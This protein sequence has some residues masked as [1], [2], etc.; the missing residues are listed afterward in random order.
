MVHDEM[1]CTESITTATSFT[2]FIIC[3]FNNTHVSGDTN[4][5]MVDSLALSSV[6]DLC[7]HFEKQVY[8]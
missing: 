6:G 4:V 5:W 2:L 7:I 8:R 3:R 1:K